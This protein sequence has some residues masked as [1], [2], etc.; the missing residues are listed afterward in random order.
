MLCSRNRELVNPE[1][2]SCAVKLNSADLVFYS[3]HNSGEAGLKI[4]AGVLPAG[5]VLD[6]RPVIALTEINI[7]ISLYKSKINFSVES[8]LGPQSRDVSLVSKTEL[9][10]RKETILNAMYISSNRNSTSC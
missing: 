7:L 4:N 6:H 1:A 9:Q 2:V 8:S 5:I 3:F 10:K